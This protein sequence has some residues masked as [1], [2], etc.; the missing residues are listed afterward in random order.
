MA[1]LA[2]TTKK[3]SVIIPVILYRMLIATA[4]VGGGPPGVPSAPSVVALLEPLNDT[5]AESGPALRAP[6]SDLESEEE[7]IV[8]MLVKE[9]VPFRLHSAELTLYNM[10]A[11]GLASPTLPT[12]VEASINPGVVSQLMYAIVVFLAVFEFVESIAVRFPSICIDC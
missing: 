9:Y 5:S 6:S 1:P 8:Y 11:C 12:R 2:I 3:S 10:I 7:T 4:V